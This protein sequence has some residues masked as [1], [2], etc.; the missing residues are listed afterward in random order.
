MASHHGLRGRTREGRLAG[1]HLVHHA[2]QAVLIAPPV[3]V[4][5]AHR[6][7]RAHVSGRPVHRSR[8]RDT[9]VT[10]TGV[11]AADP[12]LPD[13]GGFTRWRVV[14]RLIVSWGIPLACPRRASAP[15]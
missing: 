11:R 5:G 6:L 13:P 2:S 9:R 14:P 15:D 10:G 12:E 1:Q 3:D 4:L 7:L 8:L